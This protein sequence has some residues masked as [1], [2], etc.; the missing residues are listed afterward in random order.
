LG[1]KYPKQ[2]YHTSDLLVLCI[3]SYH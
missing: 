2:W 1:H 3:T